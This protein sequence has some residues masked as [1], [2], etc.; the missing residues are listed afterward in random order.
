TLT[1]DL[2]KRGL[3]LLLDIAFEDEDLSVRFAALLRVD[4]DSP[5][6]GFHYVPVLFHEVEK[7]TPDLRL[8]LGIHGVILCGVQGKEPATGI[9]FHGCGC[10][11][12]K[13][14]LAGVVGQA[15]RLLRE[16]RE[17]RTGPPPRLTLNTHCQICEFRKRCLAEAEAKDDLS[18]L[19]GIGEREIKKYAKRGVFTVTQLSYTFR[20]RRGRPPGQQ[21]QVHRHA[22]QAL[23]I[24]EKK[25]HIL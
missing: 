6:G 8:L 11:E 2:L 24:R 7:A 12:R 18:L 9:L 21:K 16:T 13:A 10:Q 17:A 4:G 25:V 20:A 22:L 15:R 14:K 3:P 1:A 23:A 5:L 19:R